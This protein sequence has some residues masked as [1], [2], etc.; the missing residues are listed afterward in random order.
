MS[1]SVLILTLDEE[2]NIADCLRTLH[3]CDDIVVLDSYSSDETVKVAAG[4]GA[5]VV[6]RNFDSYAGQRNFGLQQIEYRHPWVLML[7]AD[8]RVP[9]DLGEQLLEAAAHAPAEVSMYLLRRRDHLFG[10]WI[11]RSS[12]YPTWFGRVAR[13]GQVWVERAINE[14]YCTSGQTRR[15]QGHLD[16]YPFN[17]GFSAWIARHDRYSSM[18]ARLMMTGNGAPLQ[19][20]DLLA[21]DPL[22][23][24]KALKSLVYRL[25]GR[26]LIMFLMLYVLKRGFLDGRAGLTFS[27]L[28]SWYEYMIDC[29]CRELRRRQDGLPL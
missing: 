14:E 8:E 5:R 19:V 13:I 28:R 1:I 9:D 10:R 16:H 3:W 11:K 29:K 24:R 12:G 26:P 20:G 7:D 21:T 18:E 15:L 6:Q 4:L 25:P 23:R 22:R 2:I 27:L 17:K